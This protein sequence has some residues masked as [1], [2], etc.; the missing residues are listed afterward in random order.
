MYALSWKGLFQD[1]TDRLIHRH[2]SDRAD[3]QNATV[4]L[5]RDLNGEPASSNRTPVVTHRTT[6]K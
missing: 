4:Q 3:R 2:A 1:L 6:G 5:G